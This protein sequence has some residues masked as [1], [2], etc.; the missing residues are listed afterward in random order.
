MYMPCCWLIVRW[1]CQVINLMILL[2]FC[3]IDN[4][5]TIWL[6]RHNH[7][8][9]NP[10]DLV[11]LFTNIGNDIIMLYLSLVMVIPL[12]LLFCS[13][14]Q[15]NRG[16]SVIGIIIATQA[17][18]R[19]SCRHSR[20]LHPGK[21]VYGDTQTSSWSLY[22]CTD[23]RRAFSRMCLFLPHWAFLSL[24]SLEAIWS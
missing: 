8:L 4:Y 14:T 23:L 10:G 19:S 17:C 24:C 3:F 1:D 2:Q 22:W 7:V 18:N 12:P 15:I 5:L 13:C 20:R 21:Y 6:V 11:D 9:D 16:T